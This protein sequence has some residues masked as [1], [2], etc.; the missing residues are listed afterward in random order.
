MVGWKKQGED[1]KFDPY[2]LCLTFHRKFLL[3]KKKKTSFVTK[4]V[5]LRTKNV[6]PRLCDIKQTKTDL[7]C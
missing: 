3:Q 6:C 2:R 7:K 5:L 1:K 4:F